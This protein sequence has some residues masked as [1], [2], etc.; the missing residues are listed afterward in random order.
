[1]SGSLYFLAPFFCTLRAPCALFSYIYTF[2]LL[3]TD[4]K[5]K[6][7]KIED[8]LWVEVGLVG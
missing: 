6:K 4:Q 2:L 1:M 7:K 5:K 3:F 8:G